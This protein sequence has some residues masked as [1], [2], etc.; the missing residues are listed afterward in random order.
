MAPITPTTLPPAPAGRIRTPAPA[1]PAGTFPAPASQRPEGP[2]APG[3]PRTASADG[4]RAASPAAR[5]VAGT[6]EARQLFTLQ[7]LSTFAGL[8][9]GATDATASAPGPGAAAA[10]AATLTRDAPPAR[11]L[12]P[13]SQIDIKV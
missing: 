9:V 6:G 11:P 7:T 3:A 10:P 5:N 4:S 12:R 2:T 13:G 1:R 8:V